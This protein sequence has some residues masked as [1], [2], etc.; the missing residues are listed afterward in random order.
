V[1]GL[2]LADRDVLLTVSRL[3]P[4]KGHDVVIRALP[5]IV[6]AH[7]DTVYLIAGDGGQRASLEALA[8]RVGVAEHVVFLGYVPDA[9]LPDLYATADLFVMPNR[10]EG[11]SVEG[12]GIVFLEAN[13]TGTP[14]IG[15]NSGGVPDA[16]ADGVSGRLVDPASVEDVAGRVVE[17]L[18]DRETLERL[19]RGG[20]ERVL[21][22]FTWEHASQELEEVLESVE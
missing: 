7:P 13:A 3:A 21:A 8:K 19:G 1:A 6:D 20:Y 11:S 5:T 18:S 2:D 15:G 14:V 10:K 12:F 16:V 17:L 4:R 9:D 22:E